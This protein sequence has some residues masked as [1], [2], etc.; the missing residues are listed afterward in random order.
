MFQGAQTH[1]SPQAEGTVLECEAG[2]E[3]EVI[4]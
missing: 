3:A 1:V 4:V 2:V